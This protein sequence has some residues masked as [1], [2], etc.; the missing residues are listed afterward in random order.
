MYTHEFLFAGFAH[1]HGRQQLR[2]SAAFHE[3]LAESQPLWI[4]GVR[5]FNRRLRVCGLGANRVKYRFI[6]GV[7]GIG[8][9]LRMVLRSDGG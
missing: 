4:E 8:P 1:G 7:H 5:R 9:S 6:R 2:N 3:I